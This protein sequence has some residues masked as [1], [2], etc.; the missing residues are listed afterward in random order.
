MLGINIGDPVEYLFRELDGCM[1]HIYII[2]KDGKGLH[3]GTP[4]HENMK[5]TE[6]LE[7]TARI[8]G[9]LSDG[10]E[11]TFETRNSPYSYSEFDCTNELVIMRKHN[12]NGSMEFRKYNIPEGIVERTFRPRQYI[13]VMG[14]EN[15]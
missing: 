10:S 13:R 2:T 11:V 3:Y 15:L 7:G 12:Q 9:Y 6:E 14:G 4:E 8:T 1:A 5:T